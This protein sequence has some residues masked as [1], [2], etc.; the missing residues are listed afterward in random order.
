MANIQSL[1]NQLATAVY[2]KDVRQAIVDSIKQ[3]YNDASEG[4]IPVVSTKEVSQGIEVTITVGVTSKSFI[5][6]DGYTP[7]RG[8]DYWT[9]DDLNAINAKIYS[10]V[11]EEC[12]KRTQTAPEFADDITGCT[13]TSKVYVLPDGYIYAYMTRRIVNTP[14]QFEPANA[15][16]NVRFSGSGTSAYNGGFATDY[17]P[18]DLSAADPYT[19]RIEGLPADWSDTWVTGSQKIA[20]Y[21]A[22]KSQIKTVYVR[23]TSWSGVDTS[24]EQTQ[25]QYKNGQYICYLGY[26][27]KNNTNSPSAT[28][29]A[30]AKYVRFGLGVTNNTAIAREN[31]ANVKIY[32]DP[33]HTDTYETAWMNTGLAFV[34]ADYEDRILSAESEISGIKIKLETLDT[35]SSGEVLPPDYW[36]TEVENK[37]DSIGVG[38]EAGADA[39][40]F[41][42]FSDMHGTSGYPNQN[43]AGKSSQTN[44]GKVSRYLCDRFNIPLVATSGDIMSQ[45]SHPDVEN[46]Y[47][48][49][50]NI[51]GIL[52]P[53]PAERLLAVR[54]NHD[55]SWGAASDG[56]YYLK[57]IG[58]SK[59]YNQIYRRQ[60]LDR[61]RVFG[62][63]GTYFYVDSIP[64]KVRF[65][66]LNSNTDGDGS[67]AAN[68][69]AVYN[70]QK[71]SVYGT[72]QLKWLVNTLQTV[73]DGFTVV[74]MAHQPLN[75]SMDGNIV[76]NIFAA[77]N[78][79]RTYGDTVDISGTY[80]GNGVTDVTYKKTFISA[81]FSEST[82][83]FAAFFHGH[84]HKD[85]IDTTSY[86]FPCISIT[87]AGGDVRDSS[88]A[89]RTPGTAT[90]TAIDVVTLD[91]AARRIYM[92]RVGVGS[93]RVCSY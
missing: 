83:T 55:G 16:L 51:R 57:H 42:W 11:V 84:I 19:V 29:V 59:L 9:D 80:W 46:V 87:T 88:L 14:N 67:E 33:I 81:N 70:S 28:G 77:Y 38:Q 25:L 23:Y 44:I 34:P 65:I 63:D 72:E 79:R 68:G 54:G 39:F 1:L 93:D 49:Y 21:G 13:D 48:E 43:G 18:V 20:F 74:A 2:G 3:C 6:D 31:I 36:I 30:G 4:L 85:T 76:A 40:Q 69:N 56:V 26:T 22:D 64:Q 35:G 24:T 73:P 8:K 86:S 90:E 37:A 32:F 45:T 60:A 82:G 17:I 7:V 15:A 41:V 50:K 5:I 91:K 66:M 53:I 47:D 27:G 75:T 92:T 12:A 52:S 89:E 10:I 78:G 62:G 61:E 71:V 58:T